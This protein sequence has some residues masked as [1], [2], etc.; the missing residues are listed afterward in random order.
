MRLSRP[1][2]AAT[3][4]NPN[5]S[6]GLAWIT[7]PHISDRNLPT[8]FFVRC[9]YGQVATRHNGRPQMGADRH[10]H[11]QRTATRRMAS[12]QRVDNGEALSKLAGSQRNQTTV[13]V[14]SKG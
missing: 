4:F 5:K 3:I 9:G 7:L 11:R 1:S 14:V 2:S 6:G 13:T 12:D 10:W 8:I